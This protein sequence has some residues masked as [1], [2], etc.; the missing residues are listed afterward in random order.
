MTAPHPVCPACPAL[1]SHRGQSHTLA[2]Q[3]GSPSLPPSPEVSG[4]PERKEG[5]RES[6]QKIKGWWW[7]DRRRRRLAVG[8]EPGLSL[9]RW[10]NVLKIIL[11]GV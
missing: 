4:S 9:A 5:G 2:A 10:R 1:S 8:G 7:G 6:K 3:R 11:Q